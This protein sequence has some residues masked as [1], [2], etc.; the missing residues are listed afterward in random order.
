MKQRDAKLTYD[1]TIRKES[2]A[3]AEALREAADDF[4]S[5]SCPDHRL[6]TATWLR[7]RANRIERGDSP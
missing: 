2:E 3:K 7:E 6:S 5:D 1:V 4:Y